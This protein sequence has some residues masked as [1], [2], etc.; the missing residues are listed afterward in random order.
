MNA[1]GTQL[2]SALA[3][4]GVDTIVDVRTQYGRLACSEL[5]AAY[6]Q[7]SSKAAVKYTSLDWGNGESSA[8]VIEGLRDEGVDAVLG[9]NEPRA[10]TADFLAAELGTANAMLD[11]DFN[12]PSIILWGFFNEGQSDNNATTPSY[13]AMAGTFRGRDPTRL[14]TWADNRGN[15]GKAYQYADVISNNYYPGWYNGPASGV[16]AVRALPLRCRFSSR[17]HRSTPAA[18]VRAHS[19]TQS[20]SRPGRLSMPATDDSADSFMTQRELRPWK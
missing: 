18:L 6:K 10:E 1:N 8:A 5:A 20:V 19:V 7:A 13:A 11:R 15:R 17:A 4:R 16:T 3:S 2:V 14:V 12:H 9:L